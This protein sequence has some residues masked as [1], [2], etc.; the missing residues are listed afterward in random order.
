MQGDRSG[1]ALGQ[2]ELIRRIGRGG[3]GEVYESFNR[4]DRR[5]YALKLL[6]ADERRDPLVETRFR[7]EFW[8]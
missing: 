2:F 7:H 3:M 1:T 8:R 5:R 4:A 6:I